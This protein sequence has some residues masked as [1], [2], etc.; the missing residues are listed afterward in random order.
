MVAIPITND[1]P[2]VGARV[3]WT[4]AGTV[5]SLSHL[6]TARLRTAM[7]TVLEHDSHRAQ[8]MRLREAILRSGG[9]RRSADI[10]EHIIAT[11]Q[12]LLNGMDVVPRPRKRRGNIYWS[13]P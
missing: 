7:R 3:T 1:Q 4:G 10:V 6:N 2:G 9:A 5:L 12:P 8:A 13:V 11:G